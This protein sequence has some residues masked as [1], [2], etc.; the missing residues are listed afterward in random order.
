MYNH[1]ATNRNHADMILHSFYRWLYERKQKKASRDRLRGRS[2]RTLR[3]S[4]FGNS[5][6]D[7]ATFGKYDLPQ[8]RFRRLKWIIGIPLLLFLIW[9]SWESIRALSLFQG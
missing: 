9:F 8:F 7:Q 6:F 4:V 3:F 1:P 5:F 2:P